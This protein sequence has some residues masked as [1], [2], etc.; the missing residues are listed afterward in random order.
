[1]ILI[2]SD[3]SEWIRDFGN[4]LIDK[5]VSFEIVFFT[6]LIDQT[7]IQEFCYD[8]ISSSTFTK[9]DAVLCLV[10]LN[11]PELFENFHQLDKEYITN[12]WLA[13]IK[14][15]L[16]KFPTKVHY[17]NHYYFSGLLNNM[18]FLLSR[19]EQIG[20]MIPRYGLTNNSEELKEFIK[21]GHY[22]SKRDLEMK[23]DF[24]YLKNEI[25]E[26]VLIEK[27][28]G[29]PVI[30]YCIGTTV[31][32]VSCM[33]K[34]KLISLARSFI[35]KC[36]NLNKMLGLI[37]TEMCFVM[38]KSGKFYFYGLTPTPNWDNKFCP[39][40]KLWKILHSVLMPKH[41]RKIKNNKHAFLNKSAREIQAH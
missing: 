21:T 5:K 11:N 32:G 29:V 4:Y 39:R 17:Y 40:E 26:P 35:V 22:F 23:Y 38:T 27:I 30:V 16:D 15:K 14:Y 10:K 3:G 31:I 20:F 9:I 12:E 7:P 37:V 19:A 13:F 8:R 2:V 41:H 6:D 25:D 36:I 28:T 34:I 33:G 1:M 18:F 24:S